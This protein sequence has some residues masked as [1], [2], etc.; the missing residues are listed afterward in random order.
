MKD[1]AAFSAIK[2]FYDSERD[3]LD[4]VCGFVLYKINENTNNAESL[5]VEINK[6]FALDVPSDI[7]HS[8][9]KRLRN[10][11]RFIDCADG[12]ARIVLTSDG[13]KDQQ[14][15]HISVEQTRKQYNEL[16]LDIKNFIEKKNG[17]IIS[18]QRARD[19]LKTTILNN[20]SDVFKFVFPSTSE[21]QARVQALSIIGTYILEQEKN[22]SQKFEV[23]K[24]IIY[25]NILASALES[26]KIEPNP[27]LNNLDVYFDSNI[28]FSLLGFDDDLH[29]NTAVEMLKVLKALNIKLK[30]FSFT[31]D[32][33]KEKLL[34]YTGK[35][36]SYVSNIE[37]DSIYF[38]IKTKGSKETDIL[39]LVNNLENS[40][41]KLGIVIDYYSTNTEL[42]DFDRGLIHKL[43]QKKEERSLSVQRI[44]GQIKRNHKHP[45]TIEHDLLAIRAI[46]EIRGRLFDRIESS[47]AI[48]LTA[49]AILARFDY[50][51]Y[52]HF[53]K[54][55]I[56]EVFFRTQLVNFLWFKNPETSALL[57]IRD[58]MSGYIQ[59]KMISEKLWDTFIW[60]LKK[61][62]EQNN[63]TK[64]DIATLVSL[65]ETKS[66]L[67]EIQEGNQDY[68]E[69]VKKKIIDSGLIE[70]AK[71]IREESIK[72]K[73]F[74]KETEDILQERNEQIEMANKTLIT[75]GKN[76]EL[77]C[78]CFWNRVINGGVCVILL[79]GTIS[80]GWMGLSYNI[81]LDHA[82]YLYIKIA[83]FLG[84]ITFLIVLIISILK[85]ELVTLIPFFIK[86]RKNLENK[87]VQWCIRKKKIKF[88][89]SKD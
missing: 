12:Y 40:L 51:E 58:L 24:S 66:I 17:N 35:Y 62:V 64:E 60:E 80:L 59:T 68:S 87:I 84:S 74:K 46:K 70:E 31:L 49:D 39:L 5:K 7:I 10:K 79:M 53:D 72:L 54:R 15:S 34:S 61:Q 19:L 29:N 18:L 77:S 73:K 9:L 45:A 1:I 82:F 37:V 32:E 57:P 41:N 43:T 25:G 44:G 14:K 36:H 27:K 11:Y 88:G 21:T 85:K 38:R 78:L 48:F 3:L 75:V 30:T 47:K 22:N 63:Y 86:Q 65:S 55:T 67:S 56:P 71:K 26:G 42:T 52:S 50:E 23:L 81:S 6:E 76:I 4:I 13:V 8:A 69:S 2:S 20:P 16:L 89:I 33:V 28:I 83:S